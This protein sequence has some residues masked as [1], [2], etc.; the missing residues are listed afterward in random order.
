LSWVLSLFIFT[1]FGQQITVSGF[2]FDHSTL[3][4][5]WPA[6]DAG[7]AYFFVS[8]FAS[9]TMFSTVTPFISSSLS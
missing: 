2:F 9:A 8:S 1:A 4:G 6:G 3:S 5:I 7:D